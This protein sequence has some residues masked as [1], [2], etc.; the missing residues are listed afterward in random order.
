MKNITRLLMFLGLLVSIAVNAQL[1][2]VS[3]ADY[4]TKSGTF[5]DSRDGKTYAYKKYGNFDWFMQNLAYEGTFGTSQISGYL[6]PDDPEG[7]IYGVLYPTNTSLTG[8][9]PTG[10]NAPNLNMYKDLMNSIISDYGITDVSTSSNNYVGMSKYLK[11]GGVKGVDEN[12][13]WTKGTIDPKSAEIGFNALPAGVLNK[14]SMG[15][16]SGDATGDKASFLL[17]GWYHYFMNAGDNDVK[18]V[19]RNSHHQ[20]ALRCYRPHVPNVEITTPYP[21]T[22]EINQIVS[23]ELEK[24]RMRQN[25]KKYDHVITGFYIAKGKSFAVNLET[26][27]SSADGAKPQLVIGTRSMIDPNNTSGTEAIKEINLTEG[28]NTIDATMHSGGMV[29][30][31][32][33]TQVE[34]QTPQ[35]KVRVSFVEGGQQERA[36]HYVYGVTGQ[37]EFASMIGQYTGPEVIFSSDYVVAVT[38]RE[39]AIGN[40]ISTDKKAWMEQLHKLLEEEDRISGMDDNDSNP[41]HHRLKAGQIRHL[42]VQGVSGS[43]PNASDWRTSYPGAARY[44]TEF[45]TPENGKTG[46]DSWQVGHEVGHQHQQSAYLIPLATESTVNI[47]SYSARRFFNFGLSPGQYYAHT[48]DSKLTNNISK[49]LDLPDA[50]RIYEMSTGDLESV[51]GINRDEVRFVPWEQFFYIFGDEFYHRLHRI[52]REEKKV[53]G[54]GEERKAYLIWKTSQISGYDMRKFF[55]AWGIRTN[56]YYNDAIDK[57]IKAAGLQEPPRVDELARISGQT[58]INGGYAGWLPLPLNGISTSQPAPPD[59]QPDD[60]LASKEKYTDYSTKKGVFTDIRDGKQYP[61]KTYGDK[62]WF[63]ANLDW[64]GYDGMDEATKGTVGLY[65]TADSTG[66]VY[67]RMYP[68]YSGAATA[69]LWCPEGW[70]FASQSD[71]VD[72]IAAV[73]SEYN[74]ESDAEAIAALKAGGDRDYEADGL[75]MKGPATVDLV[76][77]ALVGFNMLPAGVLN[78]NTRT[79]DDADRQGSKASFV[80]DG[81]YHNIFGAGNDDRTW[82]NRNSHH[83]G[84]VRCVRDAQYMIDQSIEFEDITKN[85]SDA[86]FSPAQATSGLAVVYT[87]SNDSI[88]TIVNGNI[89]LVGAGEVIITANQPGDATY[90]AAPAVSRKLTVINDMD[91]TIHELYINGKAWNIEDKYELG[92]CADN[93]SELVI[94]IVTADNASVVEGN[95]I[96]VKVNDPSEYKVNFT[97]KSE[98]GPTQ[99]YTVKAEKYIAFEDAV[100]NRNN[101]FLLINECVFSNGGY[102]FTNFKWYKDGELVSR[103]P[104]YFTTGQNTSGDIQLELTTLKGKVMRTCP[105]YISLNSEAIKVYPNPARPLGTTAITIDLPED[106]LKGGT[107]RLYNVFGML[108]RSQRLTGETTRMVMPIAPGTY[109]L[110]VKAQDYEGDF[111]ILVK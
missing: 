77:N 38:L 14:N 46:N 100:I 105:K 91:V 13:L 85:L 6:S 22:L 81:W 103:K 102:L 80:T 50:E 83:H 75:W 60:Q 68:T 64:D 108:V 27:V 61:Y 25:M 39:S 12:G 3:H 26:L 2:D 54:D 63:M 88:A 40:S 94:D 11:A 52:V 106:M 70:R 104:Y 24:A 109:V 31:R 44:L 67:G 82:T 96:R 53:G 16:G 21:T 78:K 90:N 93:S 92:G 4:S 74:I 97:I 29:Y 30:F 76:K 99:K 43:S 23:A 73:R 110:K 20:A 66:V 49:Y 51:T 7:K 33:V 10:W 41:L 86:D 71:F 34:G 47:Y 56:Q 57:D 17:G 9:C 84:S 1:P 42:M 65:S 95:P 98:A 107:A 48:P 55:D 5:T 19:N 36:P 87:T 59:N 15:F 89:H 37:D 111:R 28:L 72:L 79:F 35:G 8:A 18:Y 32:Y 101:V 62:D 69:D 45:N 58:F